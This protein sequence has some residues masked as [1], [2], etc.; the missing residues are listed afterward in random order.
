LL[1][2]SLKMSSPDPKLNDAAETRFRAFEINAKQAGY[3]RLVR[4]EQFRTR[5]RQGSL[6]GQGRTYLQLR[7]AGI[8]KADATKWAN[9][10]LPR[11]TNAKPSTSMHE[12][13]LAVDFKIDNYPHYEKRGKKVVDHWQTIA[14]IAKRAGLEWGGDYKRIK[15]YRHFQYTGGYT[16]AQIRAGKRPRF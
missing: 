12:Y 6:Y 1:C 2:W 11:V 13:G 7:L 10:K 16:E 8:P 14:D 3:G 5:E 9:P 4:L 15:D